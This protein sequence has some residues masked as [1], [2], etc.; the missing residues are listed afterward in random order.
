[1]KFPVF[2][3][4]GYLAHAKHSPCTCVSIVIDSRWGFVTSEKHSFLPPTGM[5][6]A[7]PVL[8]RPEVQHSW[9]YSTAVRPGTY[10]PTPHRMS[11]IITSWGFLAT[12]QRHLFLHTITTSHKR[13]DSLRL[14]KT[15]S[16]SWLPV[17]YDSCYFPAFILHFTLAALSE[18]IFVW[19]DIL[20][21][22]SFACRW[23]G[24]RVRKSRIFV[25]QDT[26][27]PTFRVVRPSVLPSPWFSFSSVFLIFGNIFLLLHMVK[28]IRNKKPVADFWSLLFLVSPSL[29]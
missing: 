7:L 11:Q 8:I 10:Q 12:L 4:K 21:H 15:M 17:I 29:N 24:S 2:Y 13:I 25:V 20:V 16:L 23:R 19:L 5:Q 22:I 6:C 28:E 3:Y 9:G 1:M 26:D 27:A 18:P 14:E